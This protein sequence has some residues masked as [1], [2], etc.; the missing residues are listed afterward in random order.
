MI[1]MT[2]EAKLDVYKLMLQAARLQPTLLSLN[3]VFFFPLGI[4]KKYKVIFWE[5]QCQE[6]LEEAS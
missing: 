5:N 1:K 2:T 6:C 4:W 3:G